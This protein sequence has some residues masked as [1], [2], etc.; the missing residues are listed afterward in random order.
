[1]LVMKFKSIQ[2][3][4]ALSLLLFFAGS[5]SLMGQGFANDP[6]KIL[7]Q[8]D[9]YKLIETLGEGNPI[10][11][12]IGNQAYIAGMAYKETWFNR[13]ADVSYYFKDVD[14]A[15]FQIRFWS[16]YLN[17]RTEGKVSNITDPVVRDSLLR[18]FQIQ[19]SLR[20]DSINRLLRVD[21][22][23]IQKLELDAIAINKEKRRLYDLDS[24]RC[25]TVIDEISVIM[26]TPLRRGLTHHTDKNARYSAV[27]VNNGIAISL[28]DF[29]DYTD[30]TFSIPFI[31]QQRAS[32]FNIDPMSEVL[33]KSYVPSGRDT[34]AVSLLGVSIQND[35]DLFT[36]VGL[37]V[38]S[39]TGSIYVNKFY[40]DL[41]IRQAQ[42]ELIDFNNDGIKEIWIKGKID[43]TS[44]C[45]VHDIYT[46]KTIE[47]II[48]FDS[49]L[50]TNE[51]L[52]FQLL[53]GFQ[54]EITLADGTTFMF[55]IEKTN[56]AIQGLYNST[57]VLL[58]DEALIPGCLQYLKSSASGKGT[59]I[60]EGRLS[61]YTETENRHLCDLVITWDLI[62]GIWEVIDYLTIDPE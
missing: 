31:S 1:M 39:Q 49:N 54:A 34:L 21:P 8:W 33:T 26:G 51:G 37:L 7:K 56:K 18:V 5:L 19:D 62:R 43:G 23:I 48:I 50:E 28:R 42:I 35:L 14:I 27:W 38:E 58:E 44:S 59:H 46:I 4:T 52:F 61:L 60:L 41:S 10:I 53:H 40:N 57:G 25:D 29:T 3:F 30:V 17:E 2:I 12:T 16:P 13:S 36:R 20:V 6:K 32:G 9:Y 15:N 11:D 24:M 55:P 45:E 47:P 22:E